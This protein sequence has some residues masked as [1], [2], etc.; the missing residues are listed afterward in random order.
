[1]YVNKEFDRLLNYYSLSFVK[2]WFT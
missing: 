2:E 1:M